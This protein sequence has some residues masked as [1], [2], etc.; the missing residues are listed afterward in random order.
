MILPLHTVAHCHGQDV[1][2]ALAGLAFG[3][4]DGSRYLAQHAD[5]SL[6]VVVHVPL[7]RES[8]GELAGRHA[9]ALVGKQC[10]YA[11]DPQDRPETERVPLHATASAVGRERQVMSRPLRQ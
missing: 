6:V 5:R 2:E 4:E 1:G 9:H 3:G 11:T 10:L 8:G 7:A